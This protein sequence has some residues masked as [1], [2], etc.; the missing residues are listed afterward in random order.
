MQF[1]QEEVLYNADLGPNNF[2][3]NRFEWRWRFVAFGGGDIGTI[4]SS[5][6]KVRWT[7]GVEG[8]SYAAFAGW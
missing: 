6:S 3:R 8:G 7:V 4:G 5:V 1:G 2:A